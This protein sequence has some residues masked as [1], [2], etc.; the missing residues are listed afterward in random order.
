MRYDWEGFNFAPPELPMARYTGLFVV[1]LPLERLRQLVLD[2][3][4]SCGCSIIYDTGEYIM[5]RETPG[6][7]PFGKL[8]TV[9]VL[10]NRS[11]NNEREIRM[12]IVMKN[13]E[14]PIYA[15]NHCLQI[16][17]KVKQSI[18]QNRQWQ[19]VESAIG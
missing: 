1:A 11:I 9:E 17:E 8:V 3:L 15:D 5:A 7:V 19:L 4:E 18:M 10:L 13:E 12:N 16:F 2:V 6:Q 14:L